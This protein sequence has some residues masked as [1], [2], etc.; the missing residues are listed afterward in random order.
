VSELPEDALSYRTVVAEFFLGLRGAGLLLSPL[1]AEQVEAWERRGLPVAV[2]CRG[3]RRAFEE[4]AANGPPHARPPRSVR[5]CRGAV[6]VEWRAF[7]GGRVGDAPPPPREGAAAGA[8]LE[9]ARAFLDE[10]RRRAPARLRPA[11]AAAAA[12]LERAAPPARAGEPGC[13][14]LAAV[15]A[16]VGAADAALL[17]AWLRTLDRP[18]RAALG[19]RIALL[20]GARAPRVRPAAHRQAL[21]AHLADLARDAGLLPLRGSV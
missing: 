19:R 4:H 15:E 7:R 3:L 2:V 16:A 12:A 9:A 18:G 11:Y 5:A 8:R 6:E 13:P 14:G 21:L 17:A 10:H 1:D 20:A